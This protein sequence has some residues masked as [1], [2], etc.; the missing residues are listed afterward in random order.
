MDID[1]GALWDYGKPEVSEQRFRAAA[2]SA[3]SD[4]VLVLQT[5]I[6][7]TYGLRKDFARAREILAGIEPQLASASAQVQVRYHLELGRTYASP[8][9]PPQTRTPEALEKARAANMRA[10]ELAQ[11]ARLDSLAIDA[12]H[13]MVMVDNAPAD[14]L[15]WNMKA[16]AYME[17]SDQA[18]ARL[19]EGT[20]RNNVGYAMHLAGRYPEAL[21]QFEKALAL[22]LRGSN[23]RATRIAYW[24]V[25]WTYRAMGR[26]QEAVD[27]Q[28]RLER[29]WDADGQPDPYVF[30]ELAHLY[31]A[32]KDETKVAFYEERHRKSQ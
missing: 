17:K 26:V 6:A 18:D 1:L 29:E 11:A 25:A 24:M 31:R 22:R 19:W 7:R 21:D 30:E 13:M 20:L 14:Q 28:L 4:D 15:A 3:S 2:A 10:L 8:V 16:L 32:L 23:V 9:H 5:Q 12:L 27:I